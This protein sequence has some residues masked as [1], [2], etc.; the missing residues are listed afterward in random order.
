MNK[1]KD[2][3]IFSKCVMQITHAQRTHYQTNHCISF[4]YTYSSKN[5]KEKSSKSFANLNYD[6]TS[7]IQVC[8]LF[9]FFQN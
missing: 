9:F 7:E 8:R 3:K 4:M 2:L 5:N 1:E 6:F